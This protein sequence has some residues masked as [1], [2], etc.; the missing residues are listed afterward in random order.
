MLGVK[1]VIDAFAVGLWR[2]PKNNGETRN[3]DRFSP[4]ESSSAIWSSLAELR[5][6]VDKLFSNNSCDHAAIC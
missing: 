4:D 1:P 3:D 6:L 5:L 2:S